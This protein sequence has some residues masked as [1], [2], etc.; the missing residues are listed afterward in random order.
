MWFTLRFS[1]GPA[2]KVFLASA[3]RLALYRGDGEASGPEEGADL[4]ANEAFGQD[5]EASDATGRAG[6]DEIGRWAKFLGRMNDMNDSN[7]TGDKTLTVT[8]S[9]TCR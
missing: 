7:N 4:T 6:P 8:P 3:R 2:A 9:K 1:T 5:S